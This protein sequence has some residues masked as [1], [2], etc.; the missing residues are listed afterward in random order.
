MAVCFNKPHHYTAL[1]LVAPT[2]DLEA[3]IDQRVYTLYNLT[4]AEQALK[5]TPF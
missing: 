2:A 4:E 1:S 5:S 3:E